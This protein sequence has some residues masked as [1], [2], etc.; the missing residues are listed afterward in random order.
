MSRLETLNNR[1]FQL[2]E[3]YVGEPDS[4]K[5]VYGYWIFVVGYLVGLVG[6]LAYLLGP[7]STPGTQYGQREITIT[8]A[9]TGLAIGIFG[10][11]LMLPVRRR[12]IQASVVGLA[13]AIVGVIG[14]TVVYPQNW[15]GGA[16]PDQSPFVIALYT[17]GV[18]VL[19]GVTA[20]VPVVTGR[21]GMFV[22]EEGVAEEPPILLG[23]A[24][25]DALFAVFRDENG[26]WTWRIVTQEAVAESDSSALTRPDAESAIERL[27]SQI[28]TASL[29]EITTAAFRMYQ[30][31]EG[32]WRWMLM[33]EDGS[34]VAGSGG[35]FPEREGAEE[36]VS[37]LKDHGPDADVI[38]I[39]GAAFN[40]Y[41]D[42]GD[43]YWE[44]LDEDRSAIAEGPTTFDGQDAAEGAAFE[45]AD[46]MT[47][48]RVLAIETVGVEL[49]QVDGGWVWRLL[50]DDDEELVRSTDTFDGRR[51]AESAVDDVRP[52]LGNAAITVAVDPAYELYENGEGWS[53]R[54]VDGTERVL[55]TEHEP[56]PTESDAGSMVGTFS[57]GAAEAEIIE[58]DDADYEIYPEGN[59]WHWRLV[60][61][62][63]KVIADSTEPHESPETAQDAIDR[64]RGQAAEADL[65]EFD[66][67]AFQVYEAETGEWRW[68][69]IDEDGTVLADSG[70]EHAS[71]GEATQAMTTLKEQA[72]DA[73]LLE[74]DTAA[75]E[76]FRDVEGDGGWGWRLI[77]EAGK[78][79]AEGPRTHPS[80]DEAK[81]ALNDL[82]DHLEARV[83]TME[84]PAF[85]AYTEGD[86]WHWRY[87]QVDG[88]IVA[89]DADSEPTRD[90]LENAIENVRP[91][92]TEAGSLVVGDVFVRLTQ[93]GAWSF[94][95]LD[96][97]R[98]VR[99]DGVQSYDTQA[100]ADE[101][102]SAI[103]DNVAAAPVFTVQDAVIWLHRTNGSWRWRLIDED[104]NV[105]A[106]SASTYPSRDRAESALEDV[107]ELIP[108][109]GKVDF[110][111]ASYELYRNAED[112][113]QW[114]LIDENRS[115]VATGENVYDDR[116]SASDAIEDVR[117]LIR[118]ASVLEIDSATFELHAEMGG[119]RWHLVDENGNP[120]A[121]SIQVY[122][123]RTEAREA[124][125][126][127]KELAPDGWI[128]FAK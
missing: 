26:D 5:D 105:L 118:T 36:S 125:E 31:E 98:D 57:R 15:P 94:E 97:A 86:D 126:K 39:E 122:D 37:F 58:I 20:L 67:S 17:F 127:V 80:R 84:A 83:R 96:T 3:R 71:R 16:G 70:E 19:A 66:E 38:H 13:A 12:G 18:A 61:E 14:F 73:D 11:V 45:A 30:N 78:M 72:P 95:I 110:G 128:R 113:W 77:D 121:E 79:V 21:K 115:A 22:E 63:R 10:I 50:D 43:W 46:R 60:T 88:T 51:Q 81:S 28:G 111:V 93:N 69:L 124:M 49:L 75:F 42:R 27:K 106:T 47:D 92:A 48:S 68:R 59:D 76:L 87:L 44:L 112:K 9:A 8:I 108:G 64:V 53:W 41:E 25:R 123:T 74:I 91:T 109:A 100:E 89:D 2:Y 99:A 116:E 65:I 34:V 6:V 120:L 40:Y 117:D 33:R 29:L 4:A 35:D 104:R 62:D 119:W 32:R 52:A 101:T 1:L 7:A 85:Q 107:R 54:L 82:V 24:L 114:R 56:L 90:D 102:I 103:Q 23:D 55:A